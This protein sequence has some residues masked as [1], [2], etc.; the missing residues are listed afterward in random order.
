MVNL[1]RAAL[2][3]AAREGDVLRFDGE[4]YAVDAAET[5]KRK[6]RLREK[7]RSDS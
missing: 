1:P 6:A 2:P 5:A 3:D 4:R 7:R